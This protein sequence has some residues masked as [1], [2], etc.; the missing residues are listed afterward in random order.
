MIETNME[1]RRFFSLPIFR[2]V[3][4]TVLIGIVDNKKSYAT[5]SGCRIQ[6]GGLRGKISS[7]YCVY[8]STV[9]A[10]RTNRIM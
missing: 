2:A 8:F 6:K 5:Q 10:C 7:F 4:P 3:N 1:L 9:A